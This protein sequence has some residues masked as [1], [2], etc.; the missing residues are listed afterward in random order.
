MEEYGLLFSVQNRIEDSVTPTAQGVPEFQRQS[1]I[2]VSPIAN[3][4][5][6]R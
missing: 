2:Y 5:G 1:R 3:A 4:K 6:C